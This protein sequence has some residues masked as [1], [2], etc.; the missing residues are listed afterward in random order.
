LRA[1]SKR[2]TQLVERRL[3]DARSHA[4]HGRLADANERLLDLRTGL[5]GRS[6]GD[7]AGLLRS[8]RAPF[9]GRAATVRPSRLEPS[10]HRHEPDGPA[11]TVAQA[12]I[13][14]TGGRTEWL[15]AIQLS[16]QAISDLAS[17]SAASNAA[18][19]PEIR[20]A[21][22]AAWE[23]RH[24]NRIA[25]WARLALA[26]SQTALHGDSAVA[27]RKPRVSSTVGRW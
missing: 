11:E 12:D 15:E 26:D 3:A 19:R 13:A 27:V 22:L 6:P 25:R 1:W 17:V 18:A 8:A 10:F 9:R 5:V 23:A 21:A 4:E 7:E 20:S 14:P 24:R 16:A 2:V